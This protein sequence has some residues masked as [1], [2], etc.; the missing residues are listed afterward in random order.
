MIAS[1]DAR[2]L[3]AALAIAAAATIAGAYTFEWAGYAPCDLCLL[4]RK[5]FYA[6]ILVGAAG[7]LAPAR[8]ARWA[9]I[10]LA[11]V[12]VASAGFGVYHAGVEWGAWAGP[13]G[14]TGGAPT[15]G[16]AQDLLR[17]LE[18]VRVVRCDQPAIR[19]LGLSLAGW[20]AILSSGLAAAAAAGARRG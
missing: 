13:T 14:C 10:G 3:C 20:N 19:I 2:R 6:A 17:Q 1:L 5:P 12:F 16:S 7:A 4:Q 18:T 8:L 9:L 15:G 11:L